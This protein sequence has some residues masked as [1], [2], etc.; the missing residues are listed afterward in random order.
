MNTLVTGAAGI[1]G[2]HLCEVMGSRGDRV[3]GI[4]RVPAVEV[5]AAPRVGEFR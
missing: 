4:D 2:R 5:G 3:R 1:L